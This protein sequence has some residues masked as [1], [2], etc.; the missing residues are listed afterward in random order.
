M[1]DARA[2]QAKKA[3]IPRTSQAKKSNISSPPQ[4]KRVNIT[5]GS[6]TRGKTTSDDF[7][8][9]TNPYYIIFVDYY[10]DIYAKFVG[11]KNVPTLLSDEPHHKGLVH[12]PL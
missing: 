10:G 5:S 9:M 2:S 4:A 6:A 8:G 3:N 1:K 7:A 12:L 11:P